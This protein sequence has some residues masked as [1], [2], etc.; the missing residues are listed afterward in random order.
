MHAL[1]LVPR[2]HNQRRGLVSTVCAFAI[3]YGKQS[4]NVSVNE[5]NR[6]AKSIVQRQ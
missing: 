3:I 4:V 1:S 5:L 6:M 2:P